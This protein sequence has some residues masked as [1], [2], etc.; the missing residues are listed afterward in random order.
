[1]EGREQ[2]PLS[3][4]SFYSPS[5]P[6]LLMPLSCGLFTNTSPQAGRPL[7]PTRR[8]ILKMLFKAILILSYTSSFSVPFTH[9]ENL[10]AYKRM[11]LSSLEDTSQIPLFLR[12]NGQAQWVTLATLRLATLI[13]SGKT[14]PRLFTP[15][16]CLAG[17]CWGPGPGCATFAV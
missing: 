13:G 12:H 10:A 1:M 11:L 6:C 9:L 8:R 15:C 4:L 16:H 14:G 5:S 17:G 3:F 2:F 7:P